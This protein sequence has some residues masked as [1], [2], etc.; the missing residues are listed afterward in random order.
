MIQDIMLWIE[1]EFMHLKA[2]QVE[3]IWLKQMQMETNIF[4]TLMIGSVERVNG[5]FIWN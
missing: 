4:P 5:V 1:Q 2:G 3:Q